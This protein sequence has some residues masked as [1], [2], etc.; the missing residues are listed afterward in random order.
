VGRFT[1]GH[2]DEASGIGGTPPHQQGTQ[3]DKQTH[4][5]LSMSNTSIHTY[6]PW[7][8]QQPLPFG[9]EEN[10]DSF[11]WHH[12]ITNQHVKATFGGKN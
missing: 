2:W 3:F 6:D 8:K 1:F 10:E 5:I 4:T 12:S 9:A 7:A 11:P